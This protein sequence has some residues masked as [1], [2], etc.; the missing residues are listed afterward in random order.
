MRFCPMNHS[1]RK[2]WLMISIVSGMAT[3]SIILYCILK[4]P[5]F[6]IYGEQFIKDEWAPFKF[7]QFKPMTLIFFFTFIWWG[8]LLQFLKPNI[9]KLN[10]NW[11]DFAILLGFLVLFASL[12]E[13]FFNFSLWG[14]LMSVTNV[15]NP[16]I[17]YNEFPNPNTPVLLV[18]ATKIIILIF[19]ISGY[20]I[21]FLHDLR[22]REKF[23]ERNSIQ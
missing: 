1:T 16:D 6:Q 12:Y 18:Y 10:K 8:S 9:L 11:L 21:Y 23:D 15:T 14:S 22:K 2:I 19:S 5:E 20:S 17:L 13:L 7:V 3:L 4:Y